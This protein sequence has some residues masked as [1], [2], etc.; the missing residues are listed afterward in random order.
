MHSYSWCITINSK[1]RTD[2]DTV[3]EKE[4]S[5]C[6]L[7]NTNYYGKHNYV[8]FYDNEIIQIFRLIHVAV[9]NIILFQTDNF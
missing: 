8:N 7:I 1:I 3:N 4:Q 2:E 5:V 6:K 9:N